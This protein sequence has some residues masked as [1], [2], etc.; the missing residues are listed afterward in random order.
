MSKIHKHHLPQPL[1]HFSLCCG[2]GE[3]GVGDDPFDES[4]PYLQLT[5]IYFQ[6]D[7]TDLFQHVEKKSVE[8]GN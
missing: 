6:I 2:P 4:M 5:T 1:S 8:M 7:H 3:R